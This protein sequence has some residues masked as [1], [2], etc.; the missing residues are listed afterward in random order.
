[1]SV[2]KENDACGLGNVLLRPRDLLIV[3]AVTATIFSSVCMASH[4][5]L[6]KLEHA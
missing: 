2:E 3:Q 6:M 4:V 1:M 5:S